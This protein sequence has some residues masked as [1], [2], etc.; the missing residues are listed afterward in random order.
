[1]SDLFGGDYKKIE[2]FEVDFRDRAFTKGFSSPPTDAESRRLEYYDEFSELGI[3]LLRND[4]QSPFAVMFVPNRDVDWSKIKDRA[5]W[6][7]F[8]R[9]DPDKFWLVSV[10]QRKELMPNIFTLLW[11][12]WSSDLSH[13]HPDFSRA[14]NTLGVPFESEPV[15]E[16]IWNYETNTFITPKQDQKGRKAPSRSWAP[17]SMSK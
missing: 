11:F 2:A 14:S 8:Y 7:E 10:R 1:V 5:G 13:D 6:E 12:R 17:T 15:E 9:V 4:D 16:W 3:R